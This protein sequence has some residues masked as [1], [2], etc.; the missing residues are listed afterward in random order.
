MRELFKNPL[1][2]SKVPQSPVPCWKLVARIEKSSIPPLG[3][4]RE[5]AEIYRTSAVRHDVGGAKAIRVGGPGLRA[6]GYNDRRKLSRSCFS[7]LLNA[8]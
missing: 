8:S 2:R 7:L 6:R 1:L 4:T 5:T 3:T